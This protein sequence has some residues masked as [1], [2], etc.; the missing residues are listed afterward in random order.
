[1]STVRIS[2]LFLMTTL[3]FVL[4]VGCMGCEESDPDSGDDDDTT[5]GDDDTTDDDDDTGD[6]DDDDD[7]NVEPSW[8]AHYF[9]LNLNEGGGTVDL[10]IRAYEDEGGGLGA[11][12]CDQTMTW[13]AV[14][15]MNPAQG[16]DY[17]QFIDRT[18]T[19]TGPGTVVEDGCW[20]DP[21]DMF[22]ES[23]DTALQWFFNP[24]AF[25]SCESVNNN[26]NL[27]EMD[28]GP[29]PFELV[30]GDPLT[31]GQMCTDVGPLVANEAGTGDIEGI[32]LL[33]MPSGWIDGFGNYS[34][35]APADTTNVETWGF[36]GYLM[37]DAANDMEATM[38]GTFYTISFLVISYS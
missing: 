3:A 30:E 34:Y 7:D 15:D 6:D 29:D 4:I 33:P 27:A 25:V 18:V 11:E 2:W 19:W 24:L 28:M 10:T 36:F 20:W 38:D 37:N 23:W 8:F 17:W 22:G 13:D 35:F 16:D 14:V 1:M 9:T 12:I 31:F 21:E 26:P 32:W 5:D